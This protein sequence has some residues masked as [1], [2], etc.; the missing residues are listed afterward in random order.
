MSNSIYIYS[1]ILLSWENIGTALILPIVYKQGNC[2]TCKQTAGEQC[3]VENWELFL[4][5]L[6]CRHSLRRLACNTECF[7]MLSKC[8][9]IKKN[10]FLFRDRETEPKSKRWRRKK[11]KAIIRTISN[12]KNLSGF[13]R[14]RKSH[15][16]IIEVLDF[17]FSFLT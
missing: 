17:E 8:K 3:H 4:K 12:P 2:E 13:S 7:F 5:H 14:K 15:L 6:T 10:L 11:I 1:D 16:L 9:S